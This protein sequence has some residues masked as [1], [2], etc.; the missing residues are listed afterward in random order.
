MDEFHGKGYSVHPIS[1]DEAAQHRHMY[2][3]V[4]QSWGTVN[5]LITV[6]NAI[7][8]IY[9]VIKYCGPVLVTLA[10]LG[11]YLKTQGMI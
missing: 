4:S 3:T 9:D 7:S 6:I 5:K 11:Y 1:G 8:I 2:A 10:G